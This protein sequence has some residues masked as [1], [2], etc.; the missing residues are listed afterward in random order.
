MEENKKS[1]S[2]KKLCLELAGQDR[3]RRPV[4]GL[5]FWVFS[6]AIRWRRWEGTVFSGFVRI[7]TKNGRFCG[8]KT[9]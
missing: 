6:A 1:V 7:W 4:G 5:P 9:K 3:V 8:P 2:P